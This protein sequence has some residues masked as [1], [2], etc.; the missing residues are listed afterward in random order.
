MFELRRVLP[1]LYLG[2]FGVLLW[3]LF[4]PPRSASYRNYE[5]SLCASNLKQIG[6]AF[7]QYTQNNDGKFPF[8]GTENESGWAQSV[9]PYA[10]SWAIFQCPSAGKSGPIQT[11]DYFFNAH[12]SQREKREV[13]VANRTILAGDGVNDAP[14]NSALLALPPAW[15]HNKETPANRHLGTATYLFVDGHVKW[16]TPTSLKAPIVWSP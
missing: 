4:V 5:R 6:L 1:Y 10:M 2:G 12:L 14:A 15:R 13:R 3:T 9:Q 7:A 11:S 16:L 8:V